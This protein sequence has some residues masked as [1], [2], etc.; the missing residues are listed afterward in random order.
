L[1]LNGLFDVLTYLLGPLGSWLRGSGRTALGWLGIL[2]LLAAAA[3]AAGEWY[4]IDWPKPDLS[5]F[6]R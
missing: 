4:G 5:R 6:G 3:W 2:A 1:V